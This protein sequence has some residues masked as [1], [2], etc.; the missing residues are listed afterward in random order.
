MPKR[1]NGEGSITKRADGRWEAR[2]SAGYDASGKPIRRSV[3][4]KSQQ[5]VRKKLR[6]ITRDIDNGTYTAPS[7]LTVSQWLDIWLS[8][9]CGAIKPLTLASYRVHVENHIKPALGRFKLTALTPHAVQTFINSLSK[10][11]APVDEQD[12]EKKKGP[13]SLSPKSVKNLHAVLHKALKQAVIVG[14]IPR[15]PS[16]NVVL[17]RVERQETAFID[18]DM[19]GPFLQ[20]I[21]GHQYGLVYRFDLFTGLRQGEILGLPWDAVDF[22]KGAIT[23]RQQLQKEKKKGGI[24]YLAPTKTSRVRQITVAPSVLAILQQQ[25]Q[26][27]LRDRLKAGSAW[28]NPWNLVFTNEIGGHLCAG[29]VY[30]HFKRLVKE[31]GIPETRFHDMRHTF[32]TL[33]LANGDDIKTVQN[34]VGHATAAFTLDVY[35]HASQKMKKDSADRMEQFIQSLSNGG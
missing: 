19:I 14:Y 4:G 23:V 5:E 26:K 12:D 9:Y 34:N 32:A 15:N 3:Y 30:N 1:S 24:Y 33:S 31:L 28:E 7:K 25:R 6:D 35:G 10:A 8:E 18:S 13:K 11:G 17:P 2:Y 16:D 22:E 21:D 27:Q 29:T 20:A